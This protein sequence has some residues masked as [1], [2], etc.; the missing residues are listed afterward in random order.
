M[1]GDREAVRSLLKQGVD[2]NASQ[3]DGM[4]ALHWAT[5]K[6]DLQ[7]A[8]MLLY[9]GAK[10]GAG[11]RLNAMTPLFFASQNGSPRMVDLLLKSGADVN[12]SIRTGATPLMFAARSGNSEVVKLMLDKGAD[13]NARETGRGETALMFAA[14][15]NRPEVIKVL[16]AHG[17][18]PTLST[19][20]IDIAGRNAAARGTR[21]AAPQATVTPAPQAQAAQPGQQPLRGARGGGGGGGS[22]ADERTPAVETMGGMTP[23]LFAA[24]QGHFAAVK[25]LL[26]GGAD[27]N[28]VN[29]GDKTSPLL[30]A[31]INGHFDLAKWLLE[32]GASP[33]LASTGG[34]TPLYAV[35]NVKWAF[36]AEYPQPETRNEKT[37]YLE[38]MKMMLDRGA[39]PNVR[40]KVD[41]WYSAYS[42]SRTQIDAGGATPFWRAA[43][44][45]DVAAMRL[46]FERGANPT[47]RSTNGQSPLHIAAGAGVHGNQ[48]VTVYGTW[49]PGVKYLVDDLRI[50]VN[51]R[52]GRGLTALH[53]AAGRGDNEMILYLVS[54]GGDVTVIGRS[55]ETVADI[56]NGPRQRIQPF[57][58]TVALLEILGSKNSHKCVSC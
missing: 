27:I 21:G 36:V 35:L 16:M 39:D 6:D 26:D 4:T 20:V 44:A 7:M 50:D 57:A 58:E 19:K 55:G 1:K 49:M 11:L 53:H 48:E 30:I 32:N 43:Q 51:E 52:D 3:G 10:T 12:A 25:A 15:S 24:R 33:T 9:A 14:A 18:K 8:Q 46:L 38:L 45:S 29:A 34:A 2:A 28:G 37:P 31:S 23:L 41:L 17:A 54:R 56:A 13:P 47:L 22:G 5:Y 40:I 42:S